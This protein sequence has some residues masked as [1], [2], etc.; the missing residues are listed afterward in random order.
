MI[1]PSLGAVD[2]P[3]P[4]HDGYRLSPSYQSRKGKEVVKERVELETSPSTSLFAPGAGTSQD[5]I[6]S[7][8]LLGVPSPHS[9]G[10]GTRW[11]PID[12]SPPSAIPP[13]MRSDMEHE[14]RRAQERPLHNLTAKLA[15]TQLDSPRRSVTRSQSS[16][17]PAGSLR[18]LQSARSLMSPRPERRSGTQSRTT[19]Q[20]YAESSRSRGLAT[21][22]S[23]S[24][25]QGGP[26]GARGET[27]MPPAGSSLRHKFQR[28][29]PKAPKSW[30]RTK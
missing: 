10:T 3:G 5:I 25:T 9:Q 22:K 6:D 1:P 11:N 8:R 28:S 23:P 12:V 21:D 2:L 29:A 7:R 24:T 27:P 26:S 17:T 13:H 30:K 18:F 16:P 19:D 15:A 20:S 14:R 4:D